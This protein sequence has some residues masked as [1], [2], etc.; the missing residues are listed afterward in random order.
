MV[1]VLGVTKQLKAVILRIDEIDLLGLLLSYLHI[2]KS[3]AVV[4]V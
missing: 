2:V 3:F 4:V 1:M